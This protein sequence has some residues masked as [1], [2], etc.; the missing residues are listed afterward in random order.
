[1]ASRFPLF[2]D[3]SGNNCI[4]FGGSLQALHRVQ[5]LLAF[6]AKVTVIHPTLCAELRELDKA[7]VIRYIPRRYYR[8]DCTN[9]FLCVAATDE[10]AMNIAISDECKAKSIAVNVINPAAF[11]TF[12]FPEVIL[13]E[14]LTVSLS[15]DRSDEYLHTLRD[16]IDGQLDAML[17][18]TS[19]K[20]H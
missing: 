7:G 15:G 11:G 16:R 2:I 14:N 13:R 1:M 19:S 10:T 4:V 12:L 20:K 9:S 8:G 6:D 17:P 18:H 5:T 3:L